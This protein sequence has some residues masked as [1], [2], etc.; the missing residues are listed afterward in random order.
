[1][2]LLWDYTFQEK[3]R[4]DTHGRK[5]LLTEPPVLGR[6]VAD[7]DVLDRG[8]SGVLTALFGSEDRSTDEDPVSPCARAG[9]GG[10]PR[11][12]RFQPPRLRCTSLRDLSRRP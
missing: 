4:V 11:I 9:P 6:E 2:K 10:L 3:L 5:I 1:M 7:H 8:R 12:W